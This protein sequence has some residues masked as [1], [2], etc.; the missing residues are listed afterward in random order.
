ME[1]DEFTTKYNNQLKHIIVDTT[2]KQNVYA[3]NYLNFISDHKTVTI[4]FGL[5]N[6]QFNE[7]FLQKRSCN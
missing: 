1:L 7:A 2:L 5:Q 6:N 3:T 4:S